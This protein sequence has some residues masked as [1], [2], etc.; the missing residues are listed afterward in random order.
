MAYQSIQS[1]Y[2]PFCNIKTTAK[3]GLLFLLILTTSC[4][5]TDVAMIAGAGIDA[6]K[7]VTL[8][9]SEVRQLAKRAADFSDSSNRVAPPDN[10]YGQRLYRLVGDH[11]EEEGRTFNYKVYLSPQ[12]NAFAMADGTIRINSALMDMTNDGE[13]RF[14][15]G[16][17]MGHVVN[18]HIKKKLMMA[19]GSSALRKAIASQDNLAGDISRSILGSFTETV[20]NA[21]FSQQE[22]R[23]ADDYGLGFLIGN[24][25]DQ[26]AAISVLRKLATLGADHSFLSSHPAPDTRADRLEDQLSGKTSESPASFFQKTM[27]ILVKMWEFLKQLFFSLF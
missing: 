1:K 24:E 25:Y 2:I 21:Q 14:I 18:N 10:P 26:Q 20:V 15:I 9:D 11:L 19:Y 23:E 16:H 22:E 8:S 5:N 6:V 4:E 3:I 12:V 27:V 7:A 17:E 13:L